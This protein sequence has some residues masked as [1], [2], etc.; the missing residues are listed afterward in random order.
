MFLSLYNTQ[1]S[2]EE[3]RATIDHEMKSRQLDYT[4]F[5]TSALTGENLMEFAK[6]FGMF[7]KVYILVYTYSNSCVQYARSFVL[8]IHAI[9]RMRRYWYR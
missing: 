9:I 4:Y 8:N 6:H 7:D 3:A 5:E 2:E 1:V